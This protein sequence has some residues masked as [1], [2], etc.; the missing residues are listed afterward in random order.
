MKKRLFIAINLPPEARVGLGRLIARLPNQPGI[1]KTKLD[2]HHLTLLFLGDTDEEVIP[3]ISEE[4]NKISEKFSPL[5]LSFTGLGGFPDLNQPQILWV[6]LD[7]GELTALQSEIAK[8]TAPLAP[9]A[10]TKPFRPHLTLARI[11]N[12]FRID[13]NQ[14]GPLVST[15]PHFTANHIYLMESQLTPR[16]SIYTEFSSHSFTG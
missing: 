6:G 1:T 2:N 11:K 9:N 14:L 7:G 12:H 8:A 4:L 5:P 13:K 15:L 3:R 16:G 10:D